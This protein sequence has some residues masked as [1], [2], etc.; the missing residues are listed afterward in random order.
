VR[1]RIKEAAREI[2]EDSENEIPR[3]RDRKVERKRKI[4]R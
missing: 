1:Q 3:K 2:T 4:D